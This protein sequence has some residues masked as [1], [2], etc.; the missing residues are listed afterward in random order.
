MNSRGKKSKYRKLPLISVFYLFYLL[1]GCPM[2]NIGPLSRGQSHL[3][4]VSH[5]V[6]YQFFTQRSP[7][8]CQWVYLGDPHDP[9]IYWLNPLTDTDTDTDTD[10]HT[11]TPTHQILKAPMFTCGKPCHL[12]T[13]FRKP[14]L[15]KPFQIFDFRL[16]RGFLTPLFHEDPHIAFHSLFRF[17]PFHPV[18]LLYC[19]F[20]WMCDCTKCNE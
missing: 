19:F 16:G 10:T 1:S 12:L 4:N 13:L 8:A 15:P 7:G 6:F 18:F 3:P 2:A 20:D 5:C 9:T 17:F 11:H 14:S